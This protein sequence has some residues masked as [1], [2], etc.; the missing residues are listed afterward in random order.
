LNGQTV[1]DQMLAV[2]SSLHVQTPVSPIYDHAMGKLDAE[3]CR[4]AA[5]ECRK[6][7]ART[8]STIDREW[9][10]KL[11]EEWSDLARQAEEKRR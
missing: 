6:E 1:L 8:V 11:A 9:W 7:A 5:E 3:Q 2:E 4:K 10:L